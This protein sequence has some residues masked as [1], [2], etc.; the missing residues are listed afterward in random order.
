MLTWSRWL[1]PHPLFLILTSY[2]AY[3]DSLMNDMSIGLYLNAL[4]IH[5]IW[6]LAH[7]W[8]YSNYM[9]KLTRICVILETAGLKQ[10][11]RVFFAFHYNARRKSFICIIEA[12]LYIYIVTISV[13]E[14]FLI[15]NVLSVA[16]LLTHS[17]SDGVTPQV[18]CPIVGISPIA[19][20]LSKWIGENLFNYKLR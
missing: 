16:H 19:V 2:F 18:G 12:R 4:N 1:F 13:W 3:R 14:Y 17:L 9:I 15:P 8:I 11:S 7:I 20:T 10:S 5:Q 6:M